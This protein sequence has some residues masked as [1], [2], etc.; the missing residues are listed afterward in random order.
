MSEIKCL[1]KD[2]IDLMDYIRIIIRRKKTFFCLFFIFIITGAILVLLTPKVYEDSATIRIGNISGLLLPKAQAIQE[3]QNTSILSD[4]LKKLSLNPDTH[5]LKGMIKAEDIVGTDLIK[6]K[7]IYPKQKL[8]VNI[9][10]SVADAFVSKNR[11]LFSKK[12][13]ILSEEIK[14]LEKVMFKHTRKNRLFKD[15][16]NE[17]AR[18]Q[19]NKIYLLKEQL[20]ASSDFEVFDSAVITKWVI[21]AKKKEAIINFAIL[22]LILSVFTAFFQ[23][24]FSKLQ[25]NGSRK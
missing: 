6:I 23:E 1:D 18:E 20:A 22:G 8:A 12:Y 24:F 9:C 2:E 4:V 3:L 13:I 21:P 15:Q 7:V 5:D 11:V 10:N 14:R 17:K 25:T 19:G 16:S